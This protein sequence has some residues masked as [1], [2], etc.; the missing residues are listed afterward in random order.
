MD[1]KRHSLVSVGVRELKNH[2]SATLDEVRRGHIITITD[3]QKPIAVVLPTGAPSRELT[4]QGF[5]A[6]GRLCWSGGKP[7][8]VR[9][10]RR[11]TGAPVANAVIEDRR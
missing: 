1:Q 11:L 2:L 10:V 8:G 4:L 7:R 6:Y 5:T 9:T 3:R